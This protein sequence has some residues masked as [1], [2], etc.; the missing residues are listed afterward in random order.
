MIKLLKS[1][2][3]EVIVTGASSEYN[4]SITIDPVLM[5]AA[6]LHPY[7]FV[8][9]NGK[10]NPSRINTYVIQAKERGKG[11]IELNGGAAQFFKKG[12]KIHIL[13]FLFEHDSILKHQHHRPAIVYTDENN[14]VREKCPTGGG[15]D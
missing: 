7:E 6:N 15:Q 1:K 12:D 11:T 2:L 4:G 13:A 10:H 3:Q 5:E 8:Q 9:V 14:H